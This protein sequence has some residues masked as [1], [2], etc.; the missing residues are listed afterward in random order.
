MVYTLLSGPMVYTVFPCFPRKTRDTPQLFFCPVTPGSGDRP[1]K[2]GCH[3]G[4]GC[5]FF[6]ST[7]ERKPSPKFI[8]P[9][10]FSIS[11]GSWTSALSGHECLCQHSC[12][13]FQNFEGL[14]EV[15]E[16]R[17]PPRSAPERTLWHRLIPITIP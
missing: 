2:E 1:R 5:S 10:F 11:Q 17:R 15:L 6:P 4:G 12:F 7:R 16:P 13:C 3:C 9:N 8:W 14:T